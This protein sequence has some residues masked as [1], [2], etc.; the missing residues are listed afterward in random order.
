MSVALIAGDGVLPVEIARRLST[1]QSPGLIF[2]LC[3]D[4]SPLNPYAGKIIPLKSPNIGR[5]IREMK[6]YGA[7]KVIMAGNIPKRLIYCLP[8]IF[9]PLS[10]RVLRRA[11]HDDHSLLGAIVGAFEA[12]GIEVMPYW[13]ILPEFIAIPGKLS[14]R[15]PTKH[16]IDDM[17][18]GRE[19]LRVT[20]PCSFGQ[21]LCV[22][23]GSVVAIEA[24]EGTDKMILRAGEISGRGV[25]VKMMKPGQDM[26][27]DLPTVGTMTLENMHKSGL[28][29]L[30][31]EA[32]KT[33]ILKPDEFFAL[34]DEYNIA[35]WGIKNAEEIQS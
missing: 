6:S 29:C 18:Y 2:S 8:L 10:L 28:T 12:H 21:S 5:A 16:E 13:Q 14:S 23:D 11:L 9:D 31:V 27:Y 7:D 35:V 3:R 17:N 24:M 22:A 33:L 15:S 25:V 30:A 32:G 1:L 4:P 19:I 34:A 26:R 20:L